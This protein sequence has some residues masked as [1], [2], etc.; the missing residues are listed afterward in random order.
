MIAFTPDPWITGIV[1]LL[2]GGGGKFAYDAFVQWRASPPRGIRQQSLV[3]ANI[4]TVARARDELEEDNVRLRTIIAEERKQRA[5]VERLH[6]SD[7][8]RWD[9]DRERLRADVD[10]LERRL[11]AEQAEASARYDALLI[12]VHQLQARTHN[13]ET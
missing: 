2:T 3:D 7:R 9:L 5:E 12:Q 6:E 10:R 1:A 11:R 4:A 13:Q 8:T